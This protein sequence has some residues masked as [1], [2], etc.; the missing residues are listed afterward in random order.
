MSED[1]PSSL[2]LAPLDLLLN[3]IGND[4]PTDDFIGSMLGTGSTI[5]KRKRGLIEVN[6][7]R[8][9]IQKTITKHLTADSFG[10]SKVI[11]WHPNTAQ[12]SYRQEKR[13]LNPPPILRVSGPI[14]PVLTSVS[15]TPT[16]DSLHMKTQTHHIPLLTEEPRSEGKVNKEKMIRET[17][18]KSGFGAGLG[19]AKAFSRERQALSDGLAFPALWVNESIGKLKEFNLE[20]LLGS[21]GQD[22]ESAA[23]VVQEPSQLPAE[24]T[25][26]VPGLAVGESGAQDQA[27]EDN[28]LI[29][30][31]IVDTEPTTADAP[32]VAPK[33][34]VWATFPSLP[35]SVVSKPSQKTVKARN[36]ASCLRDSDSFAL[37][38]RINSQ[39]VRTKYL[40]IDAGPRLASRT[41]QWTPFK[42]DVITR[43][44]P[45]DVNTKRPRFAGQVEPNDVLTYGSIVS[46][47]DVQSGI[48]SEPM[49]VVKVEHN[50]VLDDRDGHPISELQRVAFLRQH[51]N[52]DRPRWFLSAPGARA[53]GGELLS[54]QPGGKRRKKDE[55]P[56]NDALVEQTL[57]G[58]ASESDDRLA[59]AGLPEDVREALM[60]MV[61]KG[62]HLPKRPKT[63]RNAL[64][65]ATLAEHEGTGLQ[66]ALEW[67]QASTEERTVEGVTQ[68][69]ESVPDWMSY[70]ITGISSFSFSFFDGMQ[71]DMLPRFDMPL[72]P[73]PRILAEPLYHHDLQVVDVILS[74]YHLMD[75]PLDVYLGPIGPLSVTIWRSTA[76][77]ERMMLKPG[78]QHTAVSLDAEP[79][80]TVQAPLSDFPGA[81][82]HVLVRVEMPD[83]DTIISV[84]KSC[85]AAKEPKA[86]AIEV[87][88]DG[89]PVDETQ[90]IQEALKNAEEAFN[91]DQNQQQQVVDSIDRVFETEDMPIDPSIMVEQSTDGQADPTLEATE[92]MEG[93]NVDQPQHEMLIDNTELEARN[94]TSCS[95]M[96]QLS[97]PVKEERR[98]DFVPLPFLLLRSDGVG[99]GMGKSV[100][101]ERF[102]DESQS[103]ETARWGLR[104]VPT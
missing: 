83:A 22:P 91:Q 15:L 53:G 31:A 21:P 5:R 65:M 71:Y 66:N 6:I 24:E 12:K 95:T 82:P 55:V 45:P 52:D 16:I 20:L 103:S 7:Q 74:E 97:T 84:M 8:S 40:K 80:T 42:F 79:L 38:C 34:S 89:W 1:D 86:P 77:L 56:T 51:G 28:A 69:F 76:P 98:T 68:E 88:N 33:P 70:I 39:S 37:C 75:S 81:T 23:Q 93:D 64:A 9:K 58:L 54:E 41:G 35:L 87:E 3:A 72:D 29:D 85:A 48:R 25:A 101:A 94:P 60:E 14:L 102:P 17:A 78:Q 67:M 11:V 50:E 73:I 100:V 32:P 30:P 4:S 46:L 62:E 59:E 57:N 99:F 44:S 27:A 63:K 10:F 96:V 18:A 47:V 19:R 61:S 13:M 26:A 90:A 49:K 92:A 36:I 104:V 2:P 43:A